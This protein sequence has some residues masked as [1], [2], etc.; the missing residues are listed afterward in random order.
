MT[1][2]EGMKLMCGVTSSGLILAYIIAWILVRTN[3][4]D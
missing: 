1:E 2:Y 4:P 3:S